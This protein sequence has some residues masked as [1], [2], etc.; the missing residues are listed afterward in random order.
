[1]KHPDEFSLHE[2]LH[3][4]SLIINLWDR[5]VVKHTAV[6]T[7]K[8]KKNKEVKDLVEKIGDDLAEFYQLIGRIRFE[9]HTPPRSSVEDLASDPQSGAQTTTMVLDKEA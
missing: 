1:M 8:A 9:E 6:K 5:E 2:V 7:L 4:T 3:V